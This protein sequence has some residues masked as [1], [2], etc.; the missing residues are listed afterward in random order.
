M[1][2]IGK[3]P[4]TIPSGVEVQLA[5]QTLTAKGQL[6]ALSL[7]LSNEVTT[8]IVDGTVTVAPKK[9]DQ[10]LACDV[11][12]DPGADQQYGDR[13]FDR[14]FG[15]SRDHGSRLSGSGS[16]RYPQPAARL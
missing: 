5:G 3:Y 16:R 2:R 9:R 8:S 15:Q 4:V 13:G 12:D 14:L 10:A 7:M 11:G 1:S 6:G